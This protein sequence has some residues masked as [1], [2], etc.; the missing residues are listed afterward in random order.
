MFNVL[1]CVIIVVFGFLF[2]D[3]LFGGVLVM[4]VFDCY[5]DLFSFRLG[6]VY[7]FVFVACVCLVYM[8]VILGF[9]GWVVL[10]V[11]LCY[12]LVFAVFEVVLFGYCCLSLI[13]NRLFV[14]CGCLAVLVVYHWI[15]LVGISCYVSVCLGC[16]CLLCCGF[17][18]P[19]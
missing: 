11:L 15:C 3:I 5:L 12:L 6:W 8:L 19:W 7:Y 1:I 2:D 9:W 16:L 13:V 4:I 18:L 17:G 10:P 14:I